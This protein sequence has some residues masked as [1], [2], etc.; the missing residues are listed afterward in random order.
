MWVC[1]RFHGLKP[2]H[3]KGMVSSRPSEPHLSPLLS[4][5]AS[6]SDLILKFEV[7]QSVSPINGGGVSP[8][9]IGGCLRSLVAKVACC[10][11]SMDMSELLAPHQLGFGVKGGVEAAIHSAHC[12]LDCLPAGEAMIKVDFSNAFNSA[13]RDCMLE[14]IRDLYPDIFSLVHSAHSSPSS[15]YWLYFQLRVS[16]KVTRWQ[17]RI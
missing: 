1:W 5:S 11:V 10:R 17:W 14:V 13:H 2:Q 15:L 9:A 6:F 8:I 12:F 3:L 7:P 16:S 4:V